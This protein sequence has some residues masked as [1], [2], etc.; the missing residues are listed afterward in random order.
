MDFHITWYKCFPHWDDVQWPWPG[1]ITQRSRSHKTF[2]GQEYTC[3]CPSYNLPMHWSFGRGYSPPFVCLHLVKM[4]QKSL[5]R[6]CRFKMF[7]WWIFTVCSVFERNDFDDGVEGKM[8]GKKVVCVSEWESRYNH[9]VFT[10]RFWWW[11]RKA[12]LKPCL[13]RKFYLCIYYNITVLL[14]GGE[15]V[16]SWSSV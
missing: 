4:V 15:Q 16:T 3:S 5:L 9:F 6:P 8:V 10:P 14:K 11:C 13:Y 1:S 7:Y 2:K 12:C